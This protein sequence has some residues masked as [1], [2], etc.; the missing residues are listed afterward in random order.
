MGVTETRERPEVAPEAKLA[1][2]ASENRRP[3][4]HHNTEAESVHY[5]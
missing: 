3:G 1:E 2:V 4:K 5:P